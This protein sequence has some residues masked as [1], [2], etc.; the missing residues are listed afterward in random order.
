MPALEDESDAY[1]ISHPDEVPRFARVCDATVNL[2]A[3]WFDKPFSFETDDLKVYAEEEIEEAKRFV[4][5]LEK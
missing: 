3:K 2:I 5:T 1:E 4:E